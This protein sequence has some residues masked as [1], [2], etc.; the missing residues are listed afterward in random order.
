MRAACM[1]MCAMA[2]AQPRPAPSSAQRWGILMLETPP[3]LQACV[4]LPE[5]LRRGWLLDHLPDVGNELA[6]SADIAITLRS[7]QLPLHSAVLAANSCVLRQALSAADSATGKAAA[8]QEAFE[9]HPL[10]GVQLFLRCLYSDSNAATAGEA[11]PWALASAAALAHEL[12][13]AAVLQASV[14]WWGSPA[15]CAG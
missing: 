8:V 4:S 1:P 2:R 5:L 14:V 9:G 10:P 11:D 6:A 13:C 7:R 12:E 15:A 3:C